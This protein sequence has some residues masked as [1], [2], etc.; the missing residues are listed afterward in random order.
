MRIL[1][2]H[3]HF[4]FYPKNE[5]EIYRFE[6][7]FDE[8]IVRVDDFYTFD[9]L[10][11]A[12]DYSLIGKNYLGLPAVAGFEGNPW[13]VMEA[14]GFVYNVALG[15]VVPKTTILTVVSIDISESFYTTENPFIQPGSLNVDGSRIL[16]YDANYSVDTSQLRIFEVQYG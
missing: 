16:S 2:R 11:E 3:G 8:E 14:N 6:N 5:N 9:F 4:A 12:P 10:S 13:D 7:L 1:C 15:L